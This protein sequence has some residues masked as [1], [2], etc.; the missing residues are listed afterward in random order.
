MIVALLFAAA[1]GSVEA[2]RLNHRDSSIPRTPDGRL[3]LSA[4]RRCVVGQRESRTF[5]DS[6]R[7]SAPVSEIVRVLGPESPYI[8][9]L[10]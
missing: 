9:S 4:C 1:L 6:G 10:T 8:F 2:Q 3:N 5:L 7:P